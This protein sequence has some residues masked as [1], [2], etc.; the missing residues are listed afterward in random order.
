MERKK[1]K[2]PASP[3]R[4]LKIMMILTF[5]VSAVFFLKNLLGGSVKGAIVI[6]ACLAV[7]AGFIFLSTKMKMPATVRQLAISEQYGW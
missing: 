1:A 6:G 7:F 2:L 3:E 4:I 5:S